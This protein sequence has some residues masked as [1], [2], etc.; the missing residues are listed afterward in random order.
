M[1]MVINTVFNTVTMYR[2]GVYNAKTNYRQLL[3]IATRLRKII[4]KFN[5]SE[6]CAG[7]LNHC[8]SITEGHQ[9]SYMSK[10][11]AFEAL[12]TKKLFFIYSDIKCIGVS[13]YH[14]F[15]DNC[16]NSRALIG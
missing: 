11:R 14:T 4:Y 7:N 9:Y 1:E 13:I 8:A 15:Y 16:R 12:S 2:A 5:Y 3:E 6:S 10:D